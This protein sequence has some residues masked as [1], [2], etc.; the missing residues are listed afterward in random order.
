MVKQI[1]LDAW[2]T[3]HLLE[4]LQKGA[5]IAAQTGR[6]IVLYRQTVEREGESY[7]EIVATLIDGWVVEQVVVSGGMIVPSFT[8][9]KVFPI[10]KYPQALRGSKDRFVEVINLLEEQIPK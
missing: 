8:Q 2:H 9:Q 1:S 5:K 6:P 7:E 4:L 10:E 3:G